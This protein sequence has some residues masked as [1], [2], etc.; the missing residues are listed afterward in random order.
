M[1]NENVARWHDY[2]L[3]PTPEALSAQLHDDVV[4][5]S[6][7]VHTPQKGKQITFA[8]LMAAT[9]VF[10]N[11]GLKYVREVIDGNMAALEFV[12]E[13]EG[14]TINGID[15]VTWDDDGLITDFKVFIRPLKAVNKLH[16]KMAAMLE[17]L[18]SGK[19]SW[20]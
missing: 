2:A 12:C 20:S 19:I 7:V 18:K 6:P 8:Y 17:E 5:H 11:A 1:S 10:S 16:E 15:V 13:I 14:I 3:N 9:S 4:F